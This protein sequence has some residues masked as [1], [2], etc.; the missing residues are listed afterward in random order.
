MPHPTPAPTDAERSHRTSPAAPEPDRSQRRLDQAARAA[1]LYYVGEKTQDEIAAQL[2][3]SRQGAQRLIALARSA[4]L[5]KFRLDR[6]SAQNA[7]LAERLINRF[8]LPFCD[9][10]PCSG[11]GVADVAVSA[12]EQ[13]ETVLAQTA[14]ATLALG[15]GRALRAAV[16]QVFPTQRPQHRIVSL[17]GNLTRLGR[18]SPFEVV[19]RLADLAGAQCH[20]MPYPVVADD[21]DEAVQMRNQR[22]YR[23]LHGLVREAH[24]QF[25]GIGN[26]AHGAPLHEDGFLTGA[27]IDELLA[28]GAVGEICGRAIGGDGQVI[29]H[30]TNLRAM[31]IPLDDPAHPTRIG[32]A[33]G[34]LKV[35]PLAAALRGGWLSGLITDEITAAA[36]LQT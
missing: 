3:V 36:I 32:I 2:N 4:G 20:P 15:S 11:T 9:V 30:G 21:P 14:P 6:R 1:W 17:V 13:I 33:A 24:T 28:L 12:A 23:L 19:S 7:E 8:G 25:V 26:V 18:A 5:V 16:A 34:P 22:A 31:A 35:A 27:E 29:R 10:V